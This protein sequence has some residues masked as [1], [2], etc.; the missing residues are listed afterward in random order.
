MKWTT[1]VQGL[2][3]KPITTVVNQ[4]ISP[5]GMTFCKT[6]GTKYVHSK[7]WLKSTVSNSQKKTLKE[8]Y[9][10]EG[11]SFDRLNRK[12]KCKYLI[13]KQNSLEE[14]LMA[15]NKKKPFGNRLENSVFLVSVT[16][17]YRGQL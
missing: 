9:C 11:K 3:K 8:S 1:N 12:Y 5:I 16:K 6:S 13:E 17:V 10:S 2:S 4:D 14:K 7:E 15:S